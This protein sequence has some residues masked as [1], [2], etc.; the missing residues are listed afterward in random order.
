[1]PGE[2]LTQSALAESLGVSTMPVREAMAAL[3]QEGFVTVNR[4]GSYF[5]RHL[6]KADL[7]DIY[8]L[9][10]AIAGELAARVCNAA[11]EDLDIHLNRHQEALEEAV[12]SGNFHGME[13]ASWAFHRELNIAASSPQLLSF[14]TTAVRFIPSHFYSLVPNWQE[15]AI[16]GHRAILEAILQRNPKKARA[17]GQRHMLTAGNMLVSYF[18][19]TGYWKRLSSEADARRHKRGK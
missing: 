5:V 10:S 7:S 19:E 2:R 14:L 12:Q 4:S 3:R 16:S 9:N 1:M 6:S 13:T 17:A 8:W 11:T 18:E 15:E